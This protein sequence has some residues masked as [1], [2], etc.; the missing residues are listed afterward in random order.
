MAVDL[1]EWAVTASM[2]VAAG[3]FRI[4]WK[5]SFSFYG[6]FS[7]IVAPWEENIDKNYLHTL[8]PL[9]FI[10]NQITQYLQ[11]SSN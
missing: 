7:G 4:A 3:E 9:E 6:L 5:C 10:S 1:W 8:G 11:E 2:L